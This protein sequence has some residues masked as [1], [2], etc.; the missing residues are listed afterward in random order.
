MSANWEGL[1]RIEKPIPL[2]AEPDSQTSSTA[3]TYLDLYILHLNIYALFIV[4]LSAA[5]VI[6]SARINLFQTGT[7]HQVGFY[8]CSQAGV[9]LGC[10]SQFFL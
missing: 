9:H 7:S 3:L 4:S 6:P 5:T 2:L 1:K 8:R 10:L